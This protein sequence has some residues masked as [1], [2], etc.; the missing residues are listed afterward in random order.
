[1]VARTAFIWGIISGSR[2]YV[3]NILHSL[4]DWDFVIELNC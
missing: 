1:V 3:S 4:E 2:E